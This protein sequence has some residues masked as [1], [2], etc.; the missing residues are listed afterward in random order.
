MA[1]STDRAGAGERRAVARSSVAKRSD[2]VTVPTPRGPIEVARQQLRSYRPKS[3]WRWV[4]AA[5]RKGQVD[6]RHGDSADEAIRQATLVRAGKRPAWLTEA[7]AA[8]ERQ[9]TS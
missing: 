2:I 4:W 5:R 8:A 6:W 3:D 1:E 9:V 7:A